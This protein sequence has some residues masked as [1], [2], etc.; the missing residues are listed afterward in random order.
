MTLTPTSRPIAA[1]QSQRYAHNRRHKKPWVSIVMFIGPAFLFYTLFLLV[2]VLTTFY[3]SV[4]HIEPL[5]G[6]MITTYVGLDNYRAA[7]DD[8][9]FIQAVKNTIIWGTVGPALEMIVATALA[10]ILYFEVPLHRLFRAVWF[11]PV[12]ISGVVVSWLFRWIFNADWGPLTQVLESFGLEALTLN[13]LVD[14]PLACVIFVHFWRTFGF[15]M[16]ITLAGL[17]SIPGELVEAARIDGANTFEL[18]RKILL[19]LVRG[20]LLNVLILSFI[21]KM[22]AFDTVYALTGGGPIHRSET[23][24][25]WIYT[26]TWDWRGLDLGY[27]SAMAV[28]WFVVIFAATLLLQ[29]TLRQEEMLE[30]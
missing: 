23:V 30:F 12:L 3:N 1:T 15:S 16:V 21:G 7:L 18:V 27:P 2:P 25:T 22:S 14:A 11:T 24:A 29:R 5:G 4:H 17:S 6:E 9:W 20:T 10:L 19:P 13:W 28:L 8:R 26:R